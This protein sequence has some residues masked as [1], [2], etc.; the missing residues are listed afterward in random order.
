MTVLITGATGTVGSALATRLVADGRPVRALVRDVERARRLLPDQIELVAG[1][2]VDP[3]SVAAATKGCETVFHVAGL[4]EQWRRDLGEFDRVNAGGTR[5]VAEAALAEGVGSFVF[6]STIDVFEWPTAPGATFDESA[7]ATADKHT[8]YERS[9]QQADRIVTALIDQGLPARFVAP[10]GVFGPAPVIT[11]GANHLIRRLLLN[12]IPVSLP[13]GLPVVYGP[14]VA[15]LHVLAEQAPVGSR[16]IGSDHYVT[17]E[18]LARAVAAIEPSAKVPR[19]LPVAAAQAIAVTGEA[20]AKVTHKAPLLTT[21]ELSFLT[22][23]VR[24]DATKAQTE[25]GWKVTPFPD[26]LATTIAQ[27]RPLLQA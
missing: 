5:T 2:V 20:I 13:G 9:K 17:L 8:H 11:P 26:A 25:L 16:Y 24:P 7:L 14:D 3:P 1:D 6:T 21:G 15:D 4:P 10:A 19:T 27:L 23:D 12:Q 18:E 22:G